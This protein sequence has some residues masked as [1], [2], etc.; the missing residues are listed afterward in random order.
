MN[1][2]STSTLLEEHSELLDQPIGL[3]EIEAVVANLKNNTAH[4]PD[5]FTSE[6]YKKFSRLLCPLLHKLY[7]FQRRRIP[8]PL[9]CGKDGSDSKKGTRSITPASASSHPPSQCEIQNT[10]LNIRY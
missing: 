9:D 4:C 3:D 8:R 2:T 10:N 6:F 5:R 1:E 7:M